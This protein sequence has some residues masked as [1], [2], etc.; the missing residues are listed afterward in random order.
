MNA[1]A[2]LR[3]IMAAPDKGIPED[4]LHRATCVAVIPG[5]KKG[6]LGFSGEH[7]AGLVAC[8]KL[9]GGL[10]VGIP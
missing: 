1:A 4:V 10:E 5:L 6:G 2:V 3:E 9:S 8:R 7:G